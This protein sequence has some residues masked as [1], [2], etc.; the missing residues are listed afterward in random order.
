M[1]YERGLEQLKQYLRCTAWEHEFQVYEARLRE[2][3]DRERLYGTNEQYRSDRAWII[4]QLNRLAERVNTNFNEL[5]LNRQILSGMV[6]SNNAPLS[7]TTAATQKDQHLPTHSQPE[8]RY[9]AFLCY[10]WEDKRSVKDIGNQLKAMGLA[11]WLDDWELRPGLPWQRL[12]EQQIASINAAAVFIGQSGIGPWQRQEIEAFLRQFVLRGC[13]VIPVL[14]PDAPE[15]PELPLFLAGMTWVDFRKSRQHDADENPLHRLIWGITGQRVQE[16]QSDSSHA[17]SIITAPEQSS[18]VTPET[19]SQIGQNVLIASLGE[20]PVVVSAAYDWLTQKRSTKL[21][22]AIVLHS[23]DKEVMLALQQVQRALPQQCKIQ[24]ES[25]G[26][27]DVDSRAHTCNFLVR[28]YNLLDNA[29]RHGDRVHLLLAGGRKSMAAMMA[30][31]VPFFSCIEGLYHIIDVN[32][33]HIVSATK[34]NLRYRERFEQIMHPD[35]ELGQIYLVDIPFKPGHPFDDAQLEALMRRL[36]TE[37]LDKLQYEELEQFIQT[38]AIIKGRNLLDVQVTEQVYQ[39]FALL[40][41]DNKAQALEVKKCL[42]RM[43]DPEQLESGILNVKHKLAQCPTPLQIFRDHNTTQGFIFYHI[44]AEENEGEQI[45]VCKLEDKVNNVSKSQLKKMAEALDFS[46]KPR[47]LIDQ[48][49]PVLYR[50]PAN[51]ILIVPLGTMPMVA[52]Q[53][54]RLLQYRENHTIHKVFLVYPAAQ[55]IQNAAKIIKDALARPPQ[56][57]PCCCVP[58][59]DLVDIL[60]PKACTLYQEALEGV[61]DNAKKDYP[62]YE[63]DLALSGG[64]KGM[65]AMTIFAAR[66]KGIDHVYHTLITDEKLREDI[67]DKTTVKVLDGLDDNKKRDDLLF[68]RAYK[69]DEGELYKNFTLFRVPVFLVGENR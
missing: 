9:D 48:L 11:P 43:S 22:R 33:D 53:L 61:I 3:L 57:T 69:Q 37:D 2:N 17:N 59:K 67:Y 60:S 35:L 49:P 40:C 50:P 28:L 58:I 29:Q 56:N 16:Q 32:E 46:T 38:Q 63:I 12:L 39:Q 62:G 45:V 51:S 64:R 47:Y 13:P 30:W 19:K 6:P 4:D 26:F 34:I 27:T 5:C 68:L 25:L 44:P 18:A 41:Q 7:S 15:K 66:N 65:T 24:S 42:Y 52:T 21:D 14:L 31:V 10:N 36:S 1:D 8:G 23:T 55:E 54:Y 20:S